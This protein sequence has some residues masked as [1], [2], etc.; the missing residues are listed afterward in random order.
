MASV[1]PCDSRAWA[2]AELL[3]GLRGGP[4]PAARDLDGLDG[5][6][7]FAG[8]MLLARVPL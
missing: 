6:T 1:F 3:W 7:A 2:N 8:R 4:L 5:V